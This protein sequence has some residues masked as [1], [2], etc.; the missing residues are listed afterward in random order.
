MENEELFLK[1]EINMKFN[2][3]QEKSKKLFVNSKNID[4]PAKPKLKTFPFKETLGEE[5]TK[6]AMKNFIENYDGK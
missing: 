3:P 5:R 4:K 2:T 6:L 1:S